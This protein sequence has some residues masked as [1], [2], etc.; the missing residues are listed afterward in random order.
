MVFKV[1]FSYH[2]NF[3]I[4]FY[5]DI[6]PGYNHRYSGVSQILHR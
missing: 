3:D 1:H 5:W 4:C 6:V 2:I